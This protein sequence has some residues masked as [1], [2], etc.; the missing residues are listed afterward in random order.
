MVSVEYPWDVRGVHMGFPWGVRGMPEVMHGPPMGCQ[1]DVR[2]VSV[3]RPWSVW[4]SVG[5]P[6][7]AHGVFAG[8]L[9]RVSVG[10]PWITMVTPWI[11]RALSVGRPWV[12]A[13]VYIERP[14]VTREMYLDRTWVIRGLRDVRE[15]P[16]RFP[17]V[18]VREA[19]MSSPCVARGLSV[20]ALGLSVGRPWGTHG[21]PVSSR[22][23]ACGSLM[24]CEK[25]CPYKSQ[26]TPVDDD[27]RDLTL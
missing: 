16:V 10:R 13:G 21:L 5:H 20:G 26:T 7:V 22:W 27:Q 4:V 19:P 3:G 8:C 14:R 12:A 1:W 9:W 6:C 25:T 15:S 11:V 2:V 18:A 23:V 17:W 24:K